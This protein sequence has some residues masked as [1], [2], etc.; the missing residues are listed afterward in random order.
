MIKMPTLM[1]WGVGVGCG[2]DAPHMDE[3]LG[4][5]LEEGV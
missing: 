1:G 5:S 3:G 4:R 2:L